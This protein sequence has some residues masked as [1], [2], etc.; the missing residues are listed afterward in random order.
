MSR[1]GWV[2]TL[3]TAEAAGAA[4][5]GTAAG[6]LLPTGA[7]AILPANWSDVGRQLR[8]TASGQVSNIVTTP[9]TL[10]LDVRF[11][12]I[13]TPIVVFNGGAMQLN[14]VAKTNVT[15]WLDLIVTVRAIG[16]GTAANVIGTGLWTS[17][18]VVGSAVPASGGAGA[19]SMPASAPAVG[20]GY[21]STVSNAVDL[22]ATF[23]LTGNS[24]QLLQYTLQALN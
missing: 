3:I 16:S 18:S 19:L 23:S 21:D 6:S 7:R 17:E 12:T 9:G 10:T 24:V 14:A 5:S 8:I 20:T 15:W 4:V 11:G 2:E 22:F 1:Q 13:A